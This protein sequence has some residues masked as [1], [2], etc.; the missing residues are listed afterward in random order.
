[1]S[2]NTALSILSSKHPCFNAEV[3]GSCGRAHLPVAPLCNIRCNY[4]DRKF[5]CVNESRPGV[6]SA[7]L[8][9]HQAVEY[10]AR[11]LIAEPRISVAG[12]AGPGDPLANPEATLET[13]RLV[14]ER[15]P[16]LLLCLSS[17]G[18]AVPRYLDSIAELASHVTLTINAVDP[19]I[20]RLVYAWVRDG[21]VIYR[22]LEAAQLML[23]RQMQ[24][25][26][27]LKDRGLMVKV[28][29]IVI[30][31]VN[32]EH[33]EEVAAKVASLGADLHNL[34]PL[35]P[36]AGT[37]LGE[38]PEPTPELMTSLR[39]AAGRHV[40]QMTH[41]TRCRADAVGLLGDDKSG[42]MG[43]C[44]SA[45]SRLPR[46]QAAARDKVAVASHEGL[47]INMHLGQAPSFQIWEPSGGGFMMVEERQAPSPGSGPQ[48]W[49][50]LAQLLGDCRALLVSAAGQAPR[51]AL[52]AA[53]VEVIEMEGFIEQ[54]LRALFA[55]EDMSRFRVRSRPACTGG[56]G[57]EA[58]G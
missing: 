14:K 41:C 52:E 31:G 47:L 32:E 21:K 27:G 4:C 1:M 45:C 34:M 12:I 58:C 49:L 37:P 36:N 26:I 5:D 6:A 22:G 29:T 24:A 3:K 51:P 38:T 50:L 42:E 28:N 48:R 13:M 46:P 25:L 53:G 44:L 54:G 16:Q 15:F 35:Y 17:N 39:R 7:L 33:V 19:Q 9:P 55:G 8:K 57:G 43:S 30:P 10:M 20:G 2:A 56:G 23:E 11:V 18:L 40:A